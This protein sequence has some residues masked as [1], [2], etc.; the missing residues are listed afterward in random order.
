MLA[1][2]AE[3][4]KEAITSVATMQKNRDPDFET[5]LQEIEEAKLILYF[6][7]KRLI[8]KLKQVQQ[9]NGASQENIPQ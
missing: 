3:L 5:I 2:P 1:V 8:K 9:L 6:N 7:Q 4:S